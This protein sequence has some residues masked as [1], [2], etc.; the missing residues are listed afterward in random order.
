VSWW[1]PGTTFLQRYVLVGPIGH[2]GVSVV[3]H[4]VD[5]QYSN[6][7]AIKMLAP[8]YGMDMSARDRIRR[9]ALITDLLRHPSVPRIYEFGDA[10]MPDGAMVAYVVMELLNGTML[11]E[12]L[13]AGQL[14]WTE[15]VQIA[16]SIGDVLAVAHRRGVVHR[17]L[18]PD[19]VM[20]TATGAK[21]IDFGLATSTRPLTDR[22]EVPLL[23][24]TTGGRV[25]RTGAR[26]GSAASAPLAYP[27]PGVGEPADDVYSLGMLLYHMLTGASPHVGGLDSGFAVARLRHLAPTPVISVAGMPRE[28]ADITHACMAKRVAERPD[29]S[30]VA[31]ALWSVLLAPPAARN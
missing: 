10:P 7:V 27:V 5:T 22:H 29:A 6:R 9:E 21:L 19:N 1:Q 16:A 25:R 28:I 11:T 31:L 23:R 12:R 8:R 26:S 15:A 13:A 4:A 30:T 18:T 20:M 2:G 14:P 24:R 17:D 3:Y